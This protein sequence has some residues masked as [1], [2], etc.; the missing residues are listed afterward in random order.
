MKKYPGILLAA[1]LAGSGV[2]AASEAEH[3]A[4]AKPHQMVDIGGRRLNL[5]C[6][7]SG[8]PTVLFD[9]Y[10]GDAGWVWLDVQPAVARSTRACVYDRAGLGFSDPSPRPGTSEN[11][12]DDLHKLLQ[13][14]G[15]KPPY[16][17]VGNS[18]GG[19]NVQLY[20]LKYPAE[21]SGLVLVEA[22]SEHETERSIKASGGKLAQIYAMQ[23]EFGKQCEQEV[24]KGFTP[25]SALL[26]QCVMVQRP[27][28]SRALNAAQFANGIDPQRWRAALSENRN[29]AL[30]EQQLGAARKPFG[31]LPLLVL[32][33]GV[34]PYAVPGKPASALNK[35][36]EAE[37]RKINE[38][39]ARLSTRGSNRVVPGAGHLIEVDKPQAVVDAIGEMLSTLSKQG[40]G[41][42]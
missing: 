15:I 8:Y 11:A 9:T 14:A 7:G 36:L 4:F 1:M 35:A 28:W 40:A 38:E 30:S 27:G 13:A 22:G 18:Y 12:V 33:R 42:H 5:F 26:A 17:L 2:Q 32:T 39:L 24:N 6:S 23:D 19:L 3:D 10:S 37:N 25:K 34:S 29:M 41:T 21:V 20:T 16:V 31:D